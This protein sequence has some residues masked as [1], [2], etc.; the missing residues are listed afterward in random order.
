[1]K[2][3]FDSIEQGGTYVEVLE[4]IGLEPNCGNFRMMGDTIRKFKLDTSK[5]IRVKAADYVASLDLNV[6]DVV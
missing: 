3:I 5:L 4:R 6:S 1:M 2:N